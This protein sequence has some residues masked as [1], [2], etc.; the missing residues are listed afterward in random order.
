M[1]RSPTK[2]SSTPSFNSESNLTTSANS[3]TN[4]NVTQRKRKQDDNTELQRLESM[5]QEL[6]SMFSEFASQQNQQNNRIDSL[7]SAIEDIRSQN[8]VISSQ[9]TEIRTQ[10]DEIRS[11]VQF[12]SD[13][14][15]DALLEINNL[16]E[17]CNY[18]Q[19]V[20]KT[21]EFKVDYLERNL[22]AASIEIKN[23]P[24]SNS[25][26]RDTL[27]GLLQNLGNFINQPVPPSEI[28]N[29]FRL[30]GKGEMVGTVIV[31]FS[32]TSTKEQFMR[33]IKK[34]NK[35]NIDNRLNTTHLQASG[36]KKPIFVSEALTSA[37]K[38]LHYLTREFVKS[39]KY[40][41]CWTANGKVYI[42]EKEGK[43][44]RIIK[45]EEDIAKLR[46]EK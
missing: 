19:K 15:D 18:N 42:R 28:K 39:S 10:N 20:I 32:S 1:L 9:N 14:Y 6:K 12:L 8:S 29:I 25:E 46:K 2:A 26:T 40:E 7:H 24:T 21:L 45:S 36:P 43:P 34:Y 11:S 44:S 4:K 16:K 37:T 13:K 31:E 17:E 35:Q 22:K 5:M 23:M 41:Q 3:E 27:T 33:S 38:R 30:R